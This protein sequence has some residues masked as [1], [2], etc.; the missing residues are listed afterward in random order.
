MK[1]KS[2]LLIGLLSTA[3]LLASCSAGD[4]V[5]GWFQKEEESSSVSNHPKKGQAG[6][7][8][9]VGDQTFTGDPKT[10]WKVQGGY[11]ATKDE[12][13][14]DVAQ[15][16]NVKIKRD[17]AVKVMKFVDGENDVWFGTLGATYDF[18]SIHESNITFSREGTYNVYLN[19]QLMIFL[20]AVGE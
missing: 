11:E 18:A 2:I 20:T 14:N 8:Y 9:L 17:S 13:G 16:L 1:S 6:H 3:A 12:N 15:W 7:F 10:A 19:W 5:K 4:T